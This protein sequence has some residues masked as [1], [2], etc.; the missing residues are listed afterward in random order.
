MPTGSRHFLA[1]IQPSVPSQASALGTSPC[2]VL[3]RLLV[4]P[5]LAIT[6]FVTGT[7]TARSPSQY[8]H[9]ISKDE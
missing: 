1:Y 6:A 4:H 3:C 7:C 2:G 8:E 5:A 9:D